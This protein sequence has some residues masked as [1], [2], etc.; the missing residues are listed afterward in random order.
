MLDHIG[1]FSFI[2]VLMIDKMI[3]INYTF[4]L[5]QLMIEL[6]MFTYLHIFKKINILW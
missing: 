5:E 3:V 6:H 1:N 2:T 4:D